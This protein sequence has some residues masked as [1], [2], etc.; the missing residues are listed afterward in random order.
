MRDQE[1]LE[2]SHQMENISARC[3]EN[4]SYQAK[5]LQVAKSA[6]ELEWAQD[7]S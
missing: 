1:K 4:F 6:V 5:Q 7:D 2:K 3:K